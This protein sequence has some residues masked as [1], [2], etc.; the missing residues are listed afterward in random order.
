MDDR[1]AGRMLT[2][3][4]PRRLY[5]RA[6]IHGADRIPAAGGA[7]LVSN[8]GRLDFDSFLLIRLVLRSRGRL[9]RM[10]ADHMWFRLPVTDRVFTLAGAVD[11]TRENAA[12]L[13]EQ[14]EMVLTYPGG[15]R[16]ITGGRFGREHI[17][18][19]GRSGFAAVAIRAG[20]PVVPVAG[21]GVNSGFVFVSSGRILGRLLFQHVLRLGPQYSGYR[22]PLA[23]GIIP[24]PLPLS[25]AVAFPLP[26]RVTYFVGEPIHPPVPFEGE[27][28]QQVERRLAEQ[29][30]RAMWDLIDRNGKRLPPVS[31]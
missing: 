5:H 4:N 22:N 18:W 30:A 28:A 21:V 27:S 12:D 20:V 26:C 29:V 10:L 14:G 17:D 19:E 8:H 16:E 25:V 6:A 9:V 31:S 7:V 23:I 3:L 15:V 13:L 11:G 1:R 2:S 24:V